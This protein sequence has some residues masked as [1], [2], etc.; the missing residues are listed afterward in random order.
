MPTTLPPVQPLAPRYSQPPH[1]QPQPHPQH[2]NTMPQQQQGPPPQDQRPFANHPRYTLSDTPMPPP[3][4][5]PGGIPSHPS[6]SGGRLPG[7]PP[8]RRHEI[9]QHVGSPSPAQ[10]EPPASARPPPASAL[11]SHGPA[12]FAEMGFQVGKAEEKDWVIM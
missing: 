3:Q 11:Q 8:G 9:V 2:A 7:R 1:P 4:G 6:Q 10:S 12:T 5:M